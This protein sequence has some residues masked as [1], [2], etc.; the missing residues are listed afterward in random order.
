[1][2]DLTVRDVTAALEDWAPAG[3]RLDFDRV[4]L[5][6]GDPAGAVGSVLVALDLT[7]AVI[8]EAEAAGAGLIVTHHPLLFRPLER[9]V[10]DSL[11]PAMAYRLARAGIAYYA[12]HTNLDVA[13]AGVS[14][15]LAERLGLLDV[16]FLQRQRGRL[17]KLVTFVP[18]SHLARVRQALAAAG[19]GHIGDYTECAF[20]SGGTGYYRPGDEADPFSGEPGRLEHA[21][22]M[23]LETEVPRWRLGPVL[24]ALQEAHPYEEVAYDVF[25][26]EQEHTR[27]G[28][29]AVGDL[30]EAVPLERF[31]A[32]VSERLA[33]D[34]LRYAGDPERPVR[35]IAVCG[36]SGSSLIGDAIAAGADAFV[37]ADVTYHTFFEPLGADGSPRL[38]LIDAG[39]YETEWITESLIADRLA[40]QFPGLDV[41][42]T[43]HRT[44]PVRT[45]PAHTR[46]G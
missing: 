19:A 10:P 44:S 26:M 38:A 37:T 35:R 29:G 36:G 3:S 28:L 11:V 21:A 1:M 41:R 9:L 5:Q 15:A 4:G 7:P 32:T 13:P 18:E 46:S 34:A 17:V 33:A 6:V 23:R 39:H 16:R 24:R 2:P 45:F 30:E 20:A 14:F 43:A 25:A 12:I 22:E 42:K 8:E 40:R 27:S 31:L